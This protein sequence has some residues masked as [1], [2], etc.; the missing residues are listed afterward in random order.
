MA[1]DVE[2]VGAKLGTDRIHGADLGL[3]DDLHG[4][5]QL[6]VF[7]DGGDALQAVGVGDSGVV[8]GITLRI[9]LSRPMTSR[10]YSGAPLYRTS[11]ARM[12]PVFS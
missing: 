5:V 9:A 8:H 2:A 1:F 11:A 10:A 4:G 6:A 7:E 3:A 12:L